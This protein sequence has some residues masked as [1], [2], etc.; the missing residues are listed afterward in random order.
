MNLRKDH[1]T[2]Q[3]QPTRGERT[4]CPTRWV[5]APRGV[6]AGRL[7]GS[8]IERP[9][10]WVGGAHALSARLDSTRL[11]GVPRGENSRTMCP[12]SFVM[13]ESLSFLD[14]YGTRIPRS[15]SSAAGERMRSGMTWKNYKKQKQ[16]SATDILALATMKNAAKCE[17]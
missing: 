3:L 15:A 11:G 10:D 17:I 4:H 16:L 7:P 14:L 5:A 12:T 13:T 8:S 1:C 2:H 6:A 9:T